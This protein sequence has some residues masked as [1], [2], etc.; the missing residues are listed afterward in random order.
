MAKLCLKVE[1]KTPLQNPTQKG[2]FS[3]T[4]LIKGIKAKMYILAH[5][6]VMIIWTFFSYDFKF[7]Q[8]LLFL[9]VQ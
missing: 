3:D 6:H 5:Q 1:S 9:D 4:T 2:G 7:S 8:I